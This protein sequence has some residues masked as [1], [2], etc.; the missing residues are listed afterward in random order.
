MSVNIYSLYCYPYQSIPQ[1]QVITI[2]YTPDGKYR[3][4]LMSAPQL[5]PPPQGLRRSGSTNVPSS[6]TLQLPSSSQ[7]QPRSSRSQPNLATTLPPGARQ[8]VLG[9]SLGDLRGAAGREAVL[10]P[11]RRLGSREAPP[12]RYE[13]DPS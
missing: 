6:S 1:T 4:D 7:Q 5:M 8:P 2:P 9:V 13:R 3:P 12:P 10:A 11:V